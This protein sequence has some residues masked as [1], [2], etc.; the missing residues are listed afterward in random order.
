MTYNQLR[1]RLYNSVD[2]L[3]AE[4]IKQIKKLD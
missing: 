2:T 4:L 3:Y 1:D